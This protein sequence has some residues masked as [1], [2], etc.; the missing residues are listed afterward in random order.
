[1]AEG[2]LNWLDSDLFDFTGGGPRFVMAGEDDGTFSVV[3]Q[4]T[5]MPAIWNDQMLFGLSFDEA[6]DLVETMNQL[7][8]D[9]TQA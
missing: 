5:R 6:D 8:L 9:I 3:D 1:M 4:V 2:L 7:M